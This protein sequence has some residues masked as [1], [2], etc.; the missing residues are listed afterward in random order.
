MTYERKCEQGVNEMKK[1]L[2][3]FTTMIF[4][5]VVLAGGE[6]NA[7]LLDQYADTSLVRINS[8]IRDTD[9]EIRERLT[10]LQ[11]DESFGNLERYEREENFRSCV[12][13]TKKFDSDQV[14]ANFVHVCDTIFGTADN[15][16]TKIAVHMLLDS[17]LQKYT[18]FHQKLLMRS[19]KR[20]RKKQPQLLLS[21]AIATCFD[22]W[23]DKK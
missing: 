14:F 23:N 10:F 6:Y 22:H 17:V 18:E 15:K 12:N 4:Q 11:N 7:K 5:S 19:Q 16:R 9:K 20:S 2:V 1:V 13:R 8:E 3:G 21:T